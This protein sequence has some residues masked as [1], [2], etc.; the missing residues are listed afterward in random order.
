MATEGKDLSKFDI[1][2]D[3]NVQSLNIGVVVS[4]WNN[5]ITFN[6][7]KGAEEVLKAHQV[8]YTVVKVPGSFEL[9]MMAGKML[10]DGHGDIKKFDAIVC[11]GCVIRGET[12]HFDYVCEGVAL[13][14]QT[15]S[16]QY[17]KPVI[18][19]VLTDDTKQQSI[20]RSGGKHGNKGIE[21]AVAALEMGLL[22]KQ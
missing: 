22:F 13:G 17:C 16:A 21:C 11:L 15:V 6:L 19:G 7:L 10:K 18:F 20:D 8:T 5:D 14:I 2:T 4:K 1:I 3:P 9:P 12:A